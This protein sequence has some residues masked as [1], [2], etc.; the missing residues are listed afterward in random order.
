MRFCN[1][2]SSPVS[3]RE[4]DSRPEAMLSGRG[5]SLLESMAVSRRFYAV[6][7]NWMVAG[8]SWLVG[9]CRLFPSH[10]SNNGNRNILTA[11]LGGHLSGIGT[12][13]KIVQTLRSSGIRPAVPAPE[14]S[15]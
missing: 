13:L 3:W 12:G 8:E 14:T 4:I 11:R 6:Q 1:A 10:G 15:L 2:S 5:D 9:R 7:T